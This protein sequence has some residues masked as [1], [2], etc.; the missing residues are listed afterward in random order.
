MWNLGEELGSACLPQGERIKCGIRER[1]WG[2]RHGRGAVGGIK[3]G[4][5]NYYNLKND[6]I[7]VVSFYLYKYMYNYICI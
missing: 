3:G 4:V 7:C 2:R 5:I 6:R 1:N